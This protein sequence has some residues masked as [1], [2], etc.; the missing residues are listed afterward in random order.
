MH[1]QIFYLPT[2]DKQLASL[3]TFVPQRVAL[4]KQMLQRFS[5]I[6]ESALSILLI[7]KKEIMNGV[8]KNELSEWWLSLIRSKVDNFLKVTIQSTIVIIKYN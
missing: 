3:N 2:K 4:A 6:C 1:K 5:A 7:E 8:R